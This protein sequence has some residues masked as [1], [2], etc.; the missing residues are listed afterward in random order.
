MTGIRGKAVLFIAVAA[1][2]PLLVFGGMAVRSLQSGTEQTVANGHHLLATQAAA[3][4]FDYFESAHRVLVSIG[5]QLQGTDLKAWQREQILVNHVLDFPE[6]REIALM[7]ANGT[8]FASSRVGRS[9]LTVPGL[10]RSPGGV[11]ISS[12]ETDGDGLPASRL[13]VPLSGEGAGAAWIVAEISLEQLW[14]EVDAI[15]VGERGYAALIDQAGR[16]IAHGDP[17]QKSLV[18]NGTEASAE[19]RAISARMESEPLRRLPRVLAGG[20]TAVAAAARIRQP[21]WTVLIEQPEDEAL[22]VTRRLTTQLYFAIAIALLATVVAGSW[23]GRSF[24]RRIF[25]LTT[26][27]EAL[28]AGRMDARVN[29]TG[30]D[31]IAQLGRQFNTMADRLVELQDEIRKQERQVMFGRI[32]AG[33]VHDLSHPI[34]TIGNSCKLVVR[35]FDDLDYRKTFA[36]TVDRELANVKRVLD[37]LRNVANPVPL[38]RFPVD[39]NTAAREALDAVRASAESAELS[40]ESRLHPDALMIDGDQFAL[41]RVF[42]NLMVNAIQ[43]TPRGGSVT[44]STAL[45]S[46]RAVVTVRDTGAGIPADRLPHIF[47]DFVT[48]KRHGLGLGLAISRKIVEG[49]GGSI[50]VSSEVDRGTTFELEFPRAAVNPVAAAG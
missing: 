29:L 13:A 34:M 2:A 35:L 16:F 28:A 37:D 47:E 6:L 32:A 8:V 31:E 41:G 18:A 11:I 15:R 27:T 20:Q 45:V 44:I 7:D 21:D 25:A 17:R 38:A 3:R 48:T 39:V 26:V 33:L 49:L 50:R 5:S 40:L 43:A 30:R 22:A 19:H 42:R 9:T 12:P 46:D 24:I 36:T 23:W 1:V 10:G 14:R 4:I